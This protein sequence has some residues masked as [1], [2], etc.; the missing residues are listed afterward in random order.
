MTYSFVANGYCLAQLVPDGST[1]EVDPAKDIQSGHLVAV[2]FKKD[3]PFKAF[4]GSLETGG[5]LGVT[6][7]FLGASETT[8]GEPVYLLGQLDPP[9]VVV[10]PLK[11]LEAV[12]RIT[13]GK[14]PP[15][16]P[17]TITDDEDA[18]LSASLDLLSPFLRSGSV[19]S[20]GPD[21]RPPHA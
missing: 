7:I 3:G 21:W 9:T 15:W 11:Y 20:L 5:L 16:V 12:H 6:K 19:P 1:M 2:V 14:E 8:S 17:E 10:A 4:S 18:A 13:D